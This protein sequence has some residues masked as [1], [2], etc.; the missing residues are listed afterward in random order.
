MPTFENSDFISG[1]R[2][3]SWTR[4]TH[5]HFH[6][7]HCN[8]PGDCQFIT[9]EGTVFSALLNLS[10]YKLLCPPFLSCPSWSK[11]TTIVQDKV[12]FRKWR[13]HAHTHTHT[14]NHS[15]ELKELIAALDHIQGMRLLE[16]RRSPEQFQLFNKLLVCISKAKMLLKNVN[17]TPNIRKHKPN[18]E[19]H[20]VPK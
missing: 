10:S 14:R 3:F 2:S 5:F 1:V 6:G 7:F 16:F 20:F 18:E 15:K 17:Q 11:E 13:I 19:K 8:V 9:A 12:F 4:Y